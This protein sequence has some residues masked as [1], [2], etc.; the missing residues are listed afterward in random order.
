MFCSFFFPERERHLFPPLFL[1]TNF[2]THTQKKYEYVYPRVHR[3][4]QSLQKSGRDHQR[5]GQGESAGTNFVHGRSRLGVLAHF[6]RRDFF[7]LFFFYPQ[8]GRSSQPAK[9]NVFH[10]ETRGAFYGLVSPAPRAHSQC[11]S[12][13]AEKMFFFARNS[14]R[15]GRLTF[16]SIGVGDCAP[17]PDFFCFL[18]FLN[19]FVSV[20]PLSRVSSFFFRNLSLP[21]TF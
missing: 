7:L 19:R 2:H 4:A 14:R 11:A 3:N 17:S 5:G 1:R 9:K 8:N 6:P 15:F 21:L 13:F 20:T 10:V 18:F 16:A 12:F